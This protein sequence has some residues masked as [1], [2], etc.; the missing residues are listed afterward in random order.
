MDSK[1]VVEQMSGRWQV[2]HEGLRPLAREAAALRDRFAEI[3]FEWV[4]R[5]RNKHA[6]RLANEAMDAGSPREATG[7]ARQGGPVGGAG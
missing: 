3:T 6:D 2:K 5:E 1:L 4:P 7:R